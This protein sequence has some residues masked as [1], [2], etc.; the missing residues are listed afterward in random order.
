MGFFQRLFRIGK[1]NLNAALDHL[2]D[3][4]KMIDQILR[5]LEQD[6]A[7]VTA[8]VTSQMAVEKRFEREL[9]EAEQIVAKRDEQAR[10]ALAAGDE[11]LAREALVDKKRHAEKAEALRQS[12]EKA[13]ATSDKLRSQLNAM[14]AK[15][16]E[17]KTQRSTLIAQAQAAKATKKINETMSGIG[18]TSLVDSFK[19]MEEKVQQMHDEAE[20]AQI[21]ANEGQSLDEK[22]NELF[23][24]EK[25]L[26]IDA[27]LEALKAEL[28]SN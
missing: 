3:P 17:M 9:R 22:F 12:Y 19:R 25:D 6:V 26:E 27:E 16:E 2:E 4:V 11:A 15:V 13:K 14:K 18:S 21:L 5:E 20:A 10:K 23:K 7:K 1:A 8:A 28:K 24:N